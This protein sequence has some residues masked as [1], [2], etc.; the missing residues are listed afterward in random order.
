MAAEALAVK[1]E[2]GTAWALSTA[3][4]EQRRDMGQI[5]PDLVRV[6]T[7]GQNGICFELAPTIR[8]YRT[9]TLSRGKGASV[10]RRDTVGEVGIANSFS[11]PTVLRTL[12]PGRKDDRCGF[13]MG[14]PGRS[15]EL[16]NSIRSFDGLASCADRSATAASGGQQNRQVLG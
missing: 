9:M 14:R 12:I 11:V 6:N 13:R 2:N 15:D 16:A 10:S 5:V 1:Q 3:I 4:C 8:C 7:Q